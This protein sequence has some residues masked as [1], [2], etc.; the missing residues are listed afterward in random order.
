MMRHRELRS[1]L[2]RQIGGVAL[3]SCSFHSNTN[4]VTNEITRG[5]ACCQGGNTEFNMIFH[6]YAAVFMATK[7]SMSGLDD[8]HALLLVQLQGVQ[9]A[10]MFNS[11]H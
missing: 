6:L 5:L 1:S 11:R 7:T 9:G 4:R 2:R 8:H 3:L 10:D